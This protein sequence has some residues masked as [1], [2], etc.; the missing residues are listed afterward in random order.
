MDSWQAEALELFPEFRGIVE[1][2]DSPMALWIEPY[3]QL[4]VCYGQEPIDEERIARIYDYAAW[5]FDQPPTGKAET[6]P[7][8][9]AA[10]TFVEDIPRNARISDDLFRCM[11]AESFKG[12]EPL[13]RYRLRDQEF[14]RFAA[15]FHEKKKSYRGPTRL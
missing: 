13:F 1:E 7:A 6:D 12:F 14:D 10:V 8:G 2:Q 11:S 15:S 9:A 5:C 4:V 3:Y